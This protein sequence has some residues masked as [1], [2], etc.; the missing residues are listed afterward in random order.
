MKR[1]ITAETALR[2]SKYFGNSAEFWLWLQ[3]DYDLEENRIA[4]KKEL[5]SIRTVT[6]PRAA[7]S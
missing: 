3:N 7:N 4:L 1:S 6:E 2:F 5:E